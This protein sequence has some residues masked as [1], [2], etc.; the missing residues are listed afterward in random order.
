MGGAKLLWGVVCD[1]SV[2][3]ALFPD[4]PRR[5]DS[6]QQQGPAPADL[7]LIS[8][9]NM[10]LRTILPA[11]LCISAACLQAACG[12]APRRGPKVTEKVGAD[13]ALACVKPTLH[14]FCVR[15]LLRTANGH[16]RAHT[17]R[18][19]A[20]RMFVIKRG[21]MNL[22]PFKHRSFQ[23][24]LYPS[25]THARMLSCT[26]VHSDES[27]PPPRVVHAQMR[28]PKGNP[29]MLI[30]KTAAGSFYSHSCCLKIGKPLHLKWKTAEKTH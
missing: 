18:G 16:T 25:R 5:L 22:K 29:F 11:V 30:M 21:K 10:E 26:R 6:Q 9:V 24:A 27:V 20:K 17:W 23:K 19:W 13:A 15:R 3:R 14:Y 28:T 8:P 7:P 4:Q 2:F 12:T 1:A